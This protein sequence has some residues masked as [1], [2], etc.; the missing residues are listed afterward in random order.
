[1]SINSALPRLLLIDMTPMGGVSATGALKEVYFG[2]WPGDRILQ[3]HEDAPG[4]PTLINPTG[5]SSGKDVNGD[6]IADA[7]ARFDPEV[8]LYRPVADRPALH[9]RAMTLIAALGA[10]HII[11]MMDDWP[12]RLRQTD[13]AHF[14]SM[15]RDLRILVQSAARNFAISEPMARVFSER[16]D[17]SFGTARNGVRRSDW[18]RNFGPSRKDEI[19]MRYAGS[20]APDTTKNSVLTAAAVAAALHDENPK[21]RF[22]IR[23]QAHWC[24]QYCKE[25]DQFGGVSIEASNDTPA[26]YRRWLMTAD[27]LLIAYNFDDETERYLKYSF[28]NKVPE[29]LASGAAIVV[30]G[31]KS[32]ETVRYLTETSAVVAV[33]E[34]EPDQLR[35]ELAALITDD[36]KQ[37]RLGESARNLAFSE[38]E[39]QRAKTSFLAEIESV[40]ARKPRVWKGGCTIDESGFVYSVLGAE[41]HT[42]VMV[43]VGA[44]EGAALA[45][46]AA[47]GWKVL[48]F[49]PDPR[50]RRALISAY[51]RRDNVLIFPQAIGDH[52]QKGVPFFT[53]KISTGI[54]GLHAFH[55]SH[56]ESARVDMTTLNAALKGESF[57]AADFLKIDVEGYEKAVLDGFDLARFTPRAVVAEFDD[58][59]TTKLGYAMHDL[60]KLLRD[61]RYEV[62]VSE[63]APIT[64]YGADHTWRRLIQYPCV[65][66]PGAWGNLIA[67]KDAPTDDQIDMAIRKNTI[68]QFAR[69]TPSLK[70][71]LLQKMITHHPVKAELLRILRWAPRALAGRQRLV[72]LWLTIATL[73][74]LL[75]AIVSTVSPAWWAL[76]WAVAASMA[77]VHLIIAYGLERLE[78]FETERLDSLNRLQNDL[79]RARADKGVA[80]TNT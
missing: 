71:R 19:I 64:E 52:E 34:N 7:C 26:E 10:P 33:T 31:P 4:K 8:I 66:A 80:D 65:T 41:K 61:Y 76:L 24:N 36:A 32:I 43:D 67:F 50:N 62:F 49:E 78:V 20:L 25:F 74:T 37:R 72:L 35:I 69:P 5:A 77:L 46:F 42:G 79:K 53:S 68:D 29:A 14:E 45:P 9:A 44:H 47:A 63:W 15:D 23:T 17:A 70:E 22:E 75:G 60:A 58:A 48:A 57:D 56:S 39:L 1:M 73:F 51:G 12:D 30:F 6:A 2:D 3:L 11:W 21:F 27:V 38:F 54:S 18:E 13:P 16:Y 59:K 40:A 55:N 28:A